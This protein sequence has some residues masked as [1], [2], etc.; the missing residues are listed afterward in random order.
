MGDSPVAS[1]DSGREAFVNR[2]AGHLMSR[3]AEGVAA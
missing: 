1:V 3:P 2:L